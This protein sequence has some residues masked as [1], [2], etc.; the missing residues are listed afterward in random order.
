VD[1]IRTADDVRRA[2]EG[3]RD[4]AAMIPGSARARF[5]ELA[6][7]PR[8]NQSEAREFATLLAAATAPDDEGARNDGPSADDLLAA[9]A[10]IE[11]PEPDLD[12]IGSAT[13]TNDGLTA[14]GGIL[15]WL[16]PRNL[17]KPFTVWQMKDRAG[18]VGAHGVAP[19]LEALLAHS[20]ARVH[21]LGHSYGC[22]VV[23]TAVSKP[24]TL[25]RKVESAL[26]LQPRCPTTRSRRRCPTVTYPAGFTSR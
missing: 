9:A 5:Y 10:S 12:E 13:G 21:L 18:V 26:L 3:I 22:K 6:Q 23:M 15:E 8:L 7:G 2:T 16:D 1:L 17:L 14:A 4:I 11:E 19:L 24:A 20:S 25:T